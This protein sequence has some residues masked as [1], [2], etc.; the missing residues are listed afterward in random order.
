M[1]GA[2]T[3]HSGS[4][5]AWADENNNGN[6]TCDALDASDATA[7]DIDFWFMKDDTEPGADFLLWY[8]N[9]TGYNLIADL[10]ILGSDDVWLHYTD[11]ITDSQYFVSNF[12][13]RFDG[14]PGRR[15]NVW[16]D[17][18]V[19]TVVVTQETPCDLANLDGINPVNFKDFAILA[20]DWQLT[21]P[22]LDGDINRDRVINLEDLAQIAQ[23]WLSDCLP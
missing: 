2:A 4:A 21:S 11:T 17:D 13:I 8:Y 18:V 7:I 1:Q 23:Y 6:F 3:Y 19:V 12:R 16:V 10:D 14:T 15:E 20:G 9:G 22:D 5:S